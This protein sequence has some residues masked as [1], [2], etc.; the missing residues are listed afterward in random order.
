MT[1]TYLPCNC[2]NVT[3]HLIDKPSPFQDN[4]QGLV[5]PLVVDASWES[6]VYKGTLSLGG[7]VVVKKIYTDS[8][9][10]ST[11]NIFF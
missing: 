9:S 2:L 8:V 10:F 1:T 6:N 3:V 4:F 11:T 7:I 5:R